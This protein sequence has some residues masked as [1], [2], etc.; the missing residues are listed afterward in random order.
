MKG[1]FLT[2]ISLLKGLSVQQALWYTCSLR[3]ALLYD[4][5][6][7]TRQ[8][9]IEDGQPFVAGVAMLTFGTEWRFLKALHWMRVDHKD[10]RIQEVR[11]HLRTMPLSKSQLANLAPD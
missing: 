4:A 9:I 11:S 3:L 8:R 5:P 6:F 10:P 2:D 1:S 7:E